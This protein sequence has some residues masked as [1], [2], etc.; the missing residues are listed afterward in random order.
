MPL[1]LGALFIMDCVCRNLCQCRAVFDE[2]GPIFE[3]GI[4]RDKFTGSHRGTDNQTHAHRASRDSPAPD[5]APL[6][7]ATQASW[8]WSGAAGMMVAFDAGCAFL[9]FFHRQH[10]EEAIKATHNRKVLPTMK[11]ALQVKPAH[12]ALSHFKLFVGM[13]PKAATESQLREAFQRF[14]AIQEIHIVRHC[15]TVPT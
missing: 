5:A 11:T 7:R 4:I 8:E 13:V 14:G 10:A 1:R 6:R 12:G 15:A 9:T 2:F 3:L